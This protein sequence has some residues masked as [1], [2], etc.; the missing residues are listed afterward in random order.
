MTRTPAVLAATPRPV[1]M[2]P[3]PCSLGA[4]AAAPGRRALLPFRAHRAVRVRV[5]PACPR[6]RAVTRR[7]AAD[8]VPH[9]RLRVVLGRGRRRRAPLGR[10]GRRDR[11]ALRRPPRDRR[12]SAAESCV[13]P[14][15]CSTRCRGA[16]MPVSATAAV[17]GD[18][19]RV[20]LPALGRPAVRPGD[21]GASRRCSWCA[22]RMAPRAGWV[23]ASVDYAMAEAV[24]PS[25]A[26]RRA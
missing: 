21:A 24:P 4:R 19:R 12:R 7:R 20:R 9:R 15:R 17:A 22:C 3:T 18:R 10:G 11:P 8:P 2:T 23:Q 6:R 14:R 26:S 1:A 13:D 16:M 5:E 25:N